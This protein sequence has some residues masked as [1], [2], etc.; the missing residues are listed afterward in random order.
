MNYQ[1]KHNINRIDSF[2]SKI[3]IGTDKECWEW[4]SGLFPN[5]Y[6]MFWI[7]KTS[8]AAHR[9]SWEL[10]N[11][12]KIPEGLVVCHHCDNKKCVNPNHLFLGTQN[13]NV[14]DKVKKGRQAKGLK[15]GQ[16]GTKNKFNKLSEKDVI[17]IRQLYLDGLYQLTIATRFSISQQQ[18]SKIVR[19][20]SWAW[21][22]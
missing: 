13:D 8:V 11:K 22:V 9:F 4:T 18:V 15:N 6:G 17:S 12:M 14:Q 16:V 7:G 1:G 20:D 3:D 21:L 5:G 19:G 10:H 2:W